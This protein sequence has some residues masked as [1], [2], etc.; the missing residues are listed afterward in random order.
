MKKEIILTSSTNSCPTVECTEEN[1]AIH[2]VN[3]SDNTKFLTKLKELSTKISPESTVVF[4]ANAENWTSDQ[5]KTLINSDIDSPQTV[6]LVSSTKTMPKKGGLISWIYNLPLAP[7]N[8]FSCSAQTFQEITSEEINSPFEA[9]ITA[10][11]TA[12]EH[13]YPVRVNDSI[14]VV[15]TYTPTKDEKASALRIAAQHINIE[16]LYPE[17]SWEQDASE[18]AAEAYEALATLFIKLENWN[19]A[20]QCINLCDR[21]QESPRSLALKGLVAK[22]QGQLLEAI[23]SLVTSLQEYEKAK[24]EPT[25]KTRFIMGEPNLDEVNNCL[26][27][28]L[29]ALNKRDNETAFQH[30]TKAVF[31]FDNFYKKEGIQAQLERA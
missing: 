22:K 18:A 5:I 3:C 14:P 26:Q 4:V 30:F 20:L 29:E 23:A 21:L 11:V 19:L 24:K 7:I 1:T 13:Q 31:N 9:T 16:E 27:K 6:V 28:G 8:A 2:T 17:L 25:R 10:L 15:N 12:M